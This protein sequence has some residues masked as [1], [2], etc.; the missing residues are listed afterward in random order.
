MTSPFGWRRA[1]CA[2]GAA[3]LGAASL[4]AAAQSVSADAPA[5]RGLIVRLKDAVPHE[6]LTVRAGAAAREQALAVA[7]SDH[8]SARWRRLIAES[9][10]D[11]APGRRAPALRPVGRDQQV[12]AFEKSLSR[13]E[14]QALVQRLAARPDV[15]WVEVNTRERRLQLPDD[16]YFAE[17]SQ[18]WLQLASGSNANVLADRRRGAPGVQA[19]WLQPG[20]AGFR[21]AVVAVLDTGIT[22]HPDLDPSRILP[23]HDF[24][25]DVAFS[26][27]GNGRDADPTD[28]G[29]FV[30]IADLARPDYEGCALEHSSWHGTSIAGIVAGASNNALGVAGIH[31]NGRVLPVRVAGK[32]GAE[33]ADIVDGMRWAAG[34]PV[35]GAPANPNPARLVNISF[36]GS[37]TC[38]PLYQTAVDEL[39][40]AG[41]IVIAAAGNEHGLPTRPAS[42]RGV[43]GV[44]GLN[45]DGFKTNYANFGSELTATG[46]ATVAGDDEGAGA[47]WSTLADPGILTI[48]NDGLQMPGASTYYY[49]YGT[50]FSAPIVTGVASLMLGVNP[51]LTA[52]QLIDGLR[53]SARPHVTSPLIGA[54]SWDNPGRC[55]CTSA[56]CGAGI[57]DAEQ[58]LLYAA[59]PTT[60]VAPVRIGA[61]IDNAD[62][63][64]AAAQGPDRDPNPSSP[65]EPAPSD[66]GG[67]A[68][69][70]AWIGLLAL[71]ALVLSA[72]RRR[73]R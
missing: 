66:G 12:I 67:G 18:W 39:N 48:G 31:W 30:S 6:R 61:V 1:A 59:N 46:I 24:V 51:G 54:C 19:A 28:P 73:R 13:A 72:P 34:L 38:G 63:S 23:G 69:S 9:G 27:D 65:T 52:D 20:G 70:G 40:A 5:L 36:G 2:L 17:G 3:F 43:V 7:A 10:L 21:S 41:V 22:S 15:D 58:A 4:P 60:Y 49:L 35:A 57:L 44:V 32:C 71:A 53:R 50:S 29:D 47:R 45:R 68:M 26:N 42:C 37:N 64:A 55:I 16:P 14:A 11:A 25:S 62:V 8:E 33:V 56:T